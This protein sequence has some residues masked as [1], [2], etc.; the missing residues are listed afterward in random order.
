MSE[1]GEVVLVGADRPISEMAAWTEEERQAGLD[2]R[3]LRV[4][5]VGAHPDDPETCCGGIIARLVA[6]GHEVVNA[7]LTRGE[8]GVA[9]TPEPEAARLRT[10]EAE[11]ACELL[12]ARPRFLGQIDGD[13]RVDADAYDQMAAVI[14]EEQPDIVLTHWPLDTHRDHRTVSSLVFDVWAREKAR[15]V[16][17]YFE[18]LL[19]MQTQTF[20]PEIYVDISAAVKLKE[21]ICSA[22][23]SQSPE[24]LNRWHGAMETYRGGTVGFAHAEALIRQRWHPFRIE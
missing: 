24:K 10:K 21:E 11:T 22:H 14:E 19:G 3:S 13:T 23:A 16:L 9:D 6:E 20:E 7:Y 15:F 12:G 18:A 8:A 4:L 17:L 5:V 2:R 1:K